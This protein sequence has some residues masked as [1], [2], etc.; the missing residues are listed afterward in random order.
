[1]AVPNFPKPPGRNTGEGGMI[2]P[3]DLNSDNRQFYT[4]ISF[5]EYSFAGAT[6]TGAIEMGSTVKL[7]MPRKIND[8]ESI[9]WEEKSLTGS[10]GSGLQSAG[11]IGSM[12]NSKIGNVLSGA[13]AMVGSTVAGV[14][15]LG[16]FGQIPGVSGGATVNPFMFMM[17]R[18]PGFKEYT[19]HWTLAPNNER[20]SDNL[21]KIIKECKK[22][23]LPQGYAFGGGLMKY[24]KIAMVK[25]KPDN[26]LFKFKPCAI[27]SVAVDYTGSNGPSFFKNGAPTIVNLSIAL[28]EMQLRDAQT[29]E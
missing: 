4:S 21:L 20:D 11:Q 10:V 16:L 19:L 26:Y 5:A 23:A 25:F 3:S 6:G 27:L 2:F 28:K 22:A 15:M 12:I 1:M 9:S 8:V 14:D 7:P 17:F 13:G 24:P 29:A 18:R